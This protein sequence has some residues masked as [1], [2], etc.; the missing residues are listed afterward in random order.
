MRLAIIAFAT[1][2]IS[3]SL[4]SGLEKITVAINENTNACRSNPDG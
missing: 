3:M 1:L 4:S 2:L